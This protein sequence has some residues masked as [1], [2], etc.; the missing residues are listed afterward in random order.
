MGGE[1]RGSK[2][3]QKMSDVIQETTPNKFIKNIPSLIGSKSRTKERFG[4]VRIRYLIAPLNLLAFNFFISFP[5]M[6]NFEGKI[7]F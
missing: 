5:I 7:P 3:V 6:N 1:G 4:N 2:I